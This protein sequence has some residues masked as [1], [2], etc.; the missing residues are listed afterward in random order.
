MISRSFK[1]SL[2]FGKT[3]K[4]IKTIEGNYIQYSIQM[5]FLGESTEERW[6]GEGGVARDGGGGRVWWGK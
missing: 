6:R 4:Q 3:K 5:V 2:V 1:D